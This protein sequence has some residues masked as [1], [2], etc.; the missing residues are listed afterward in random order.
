VLL[1]GIEELWRARVDRI[2]DLLAAEKRT[3][4]GKR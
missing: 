4:G 3:T 2:D 1:A